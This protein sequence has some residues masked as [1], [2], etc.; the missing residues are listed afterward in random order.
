MPNMPGHSL[1]VGPLVNIATVAPVRFPRRYLL[2]LVIAGFAM[3]FWARAGATT[4]PPAGALHTLE[5]T[6]AEVVSKS[7]TSRFNGRS[8]TVHLTL[9][10]LD[11]H[12]NVQ[13]R[14]LE[15]P[16]SGLNPGVSVRVETYSDAATG[17]QLAKDYPDVQRRIQADS[18]Y[19]GGT[20]V[21]T[22]EATGERASG[23][24]W[25]WRVASLACWAIALTWSALAIRKHLPALRRKRDEL[26]D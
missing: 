13:F 22:A 2:L 16:M 1:R 6:I 24:R 18:L 10:V 5:G 7:E 9:L 23:W 4:P 12:P 20:A 26:L 15:P 25:G 17:L 11:G 21:Y 3:F 19:L 14:V 8:H